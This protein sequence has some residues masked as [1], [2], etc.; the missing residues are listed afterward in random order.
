MSPASN[1]RGIRQY[2]KI[3]LYLEKGALEIW[4]CGKNGEIS[5]NRMPMGAYPTEIQAKPTSLLN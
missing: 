1:N 3:R 5:Y 4:L 2:E